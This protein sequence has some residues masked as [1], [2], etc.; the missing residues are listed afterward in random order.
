METAT[1]TLHLPKKDL[2][3]AEQYA[4]EH[5]TTLPELISQHLR[6]LWT[7]SDMTAAPDSPSS[8]RA[9]EG[10]ATLL[11]RWE[12]GDEFADEVD[13]IVASRSGPR[14]PPEFET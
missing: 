9:P 13:R 11:G 10:L 12:D 7:R 5:H 8:E 6:R 4:Q 14:Q 1:L 3:L 2:E